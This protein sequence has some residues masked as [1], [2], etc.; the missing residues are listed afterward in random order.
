MT[1]ISNFRSKLKHDLLPEDRVIADDG[2]RG[3]SKVLAPDEYKRDKSKC[4]I[5]V[6][7]KLYAHHDTINGYSQNWGYSRQ[8]WHHSDEKY[9][10]A[11]GEVVDVTQ[12]HIENGCFTFRVDGYIDCAKY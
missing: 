9:A 7:G 10:L 8:I 2:Y 11:A 12:L 6:I 4:S 3:D 5:K 1:D